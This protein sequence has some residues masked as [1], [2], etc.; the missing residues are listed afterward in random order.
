MTVAADYV[1]CFM[2]ASMSHPI[3]CIYAFLSH[4]IGIRVERTIHLHN[5]AH[6]T[7]TVT[8]CVNDGHCSYSIEIST[9]H[10]S[11]ETA[12]KTVI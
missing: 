7:A 11:S 5:I 3:L 8:H 1:G 12:C 6:L 2:A 9:L 4:P 10:W